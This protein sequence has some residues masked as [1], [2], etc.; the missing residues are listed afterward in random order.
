MVSLSKS[1]DPGWVHQ[2]LIR[3]GTTLIRPPVVRPGSR[4]NCTPQMAWMARQ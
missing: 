4:R 3:M 1:I 2:S